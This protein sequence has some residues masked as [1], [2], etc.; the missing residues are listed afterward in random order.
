MPS[1]S[2]AQSATPL[3]LHERLRPFRGRVPDADW[4]AELACAAASALAPEDDARIPAAYRRELTMTL[5]QRALAA[6]AARAK[7]ER[8]G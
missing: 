2:T 1:L 8:H 5:T 7:D 6:A 3:S 4:C